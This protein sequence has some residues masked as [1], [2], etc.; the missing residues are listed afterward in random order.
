MGHQALQ[1]YKPVS[2]ARATHW[3]ILQLFTEVYYC[4]HLQK[5]YDSS[6]LKLH[7]V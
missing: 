5:E 3:G 1:T 2:S 6:W 4:V 7:V